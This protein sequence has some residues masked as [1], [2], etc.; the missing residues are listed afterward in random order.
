MYPAPSM[1]WQATVRLHGRAK[2]GR[3]LPSCLSRLGLRRAGR[4]AA[5]TGL[6][7]GMVLCLVLLLAGLCLDDAR[8]Q[9][10]VCTGTPGENQLIDCNEPDPLTDFEEI[11]L[12]VDGLVIRPP[13]GV[14][15]IKAQ[16]RA[17]TSANI[18]IDVTDTATTTRYIEGIWGIHQGDGYIDIDVTG[19]EMSGGGVKG[20]H[21][22]TGYVDITVK[23]TT[24]STTDDQLPGVHATH[25]GSGDIGITV[26]H[27]KFTTMGDILEGAITAVHR[28]S[29]GDIDIRVK[30]AEIIAE[31]PGNGNESGHN[32][33]IHVQR[34]G[35]GSGDINIAL[36]DT[37]ITTNSD[38]EARGIFVQH[39][40]KGHINLNLNP[41][42]TID[43]KGVGVFLVQQN[44]DTATKSDVILDAR[45]IAV[46]TSG[47]EAYGLWADRQ[48]GWGDIIMDIRD[49]AVTTENSQAFGIYATQQ[50]NGGGDIW[51]RLT[52]GRTTTNGYNSHGIFATGAGDI[53]IALRNHHIATKSIAH[54][55]DFGGTYSYGI[56]A[57]KNNPGDLV[58]DMR[59][60][61]ITTA[62][63]NSHG[64]VARSSDADS[65]IHITV[66]GPVTTSGAGAHGILAQPQGGGDVVI[67]IRGTVVRASGA[68]ADGIRI[69]GSG[70]RQ[71]VS[72]GS[73]VW[74]GSGGAGIRLRGGGRVVIGPDG[75]VGAAPGGVAIAVTRADPTDNTE[76]PGLDLH[77]ML[78][79]RLPEQVLAGRIQN[80]DGTTQVTANGV[81]VFDTTRGASGVWFPNGAWNVRATGTDLSTL[82]FDRVI[83]PRAAVYEALPGVLLRLDARPGGIGGGVRLRSPGTP[84]WAR[85]A[86]GV[87]SYEADSATVGANYDYDRY[88]V[89]TGVDFPLDQG[90]FEG[91]LTGWAGVRVVSGSADVSAPTG[92]GRIEATGRGLTGGLAWEGKDDWYGRGRFSLTRY[93]A[94]LSSAERGALKS[95]AGALVHAL[96]LEGGRRFGLDVLGVKTRLTARGM[97]RRSGVSLDKFDDG[98]FSR[99]SVGDADRLDAGAGVAVETG[100]LPSEG[101][102]RLTLR[103][104]L[105]AEQTLSGGTVVDVSDTLLESK[106]GG[107]RFGAGLGAAYRMDGYA[108]GGSVGAGGLGSGNTSYSGRLELSVAF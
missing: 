23:R 98:L 82:A 107:T 16:Q 88:S 105:D 71:T 47:E 31:K 12:Y 74:G 89:E 24:I 26:E 46:T 32:D 36:E 54:H 35:T 76:S 85:I 38:R 41:G 7:R 27:S 28:G 49:S 108:V 6:R 34:K 21:T 64:I 3:G 39:E 22:G 13:D 63:D 4:P 2:V 58:I 103:G 66:G 44:A 95:G 102:D 99:V 65:M 104:S 42:V 61:S 51:V 100:L 40:G 43:T 55:P 92:G 83:A 17:G 14:A 20:E 5:H 69:E 80:D 86:G 62:G 79:G 30:H 37:G 29:T 75:R 78:G 68:G 57:L 18:I 60:G 101:V 106:A 9:E 70:G 45:G 8:A 53:V 25:A 59:G 33:G 11:K 81:P 48:T 10:L 50:G 67:L 73:E 90:L 91:E 94:D 56:F 93:T 87:G 15:G 96:D 72:I 1:D 97:L 52:N 19:G 77:L 84:V